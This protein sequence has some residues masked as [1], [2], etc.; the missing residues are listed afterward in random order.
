MR[1]VFLSSSDVTYVL[2]DSPL[3]VDDHL[4]EIVTFVDFSDTLN[5]EPVKQSLQNIDMQMDIGIEQATQVHCLLSTDG[6]NRIDLEGGGDLNMIY[7]TQ[8]GLRLFGRY[9]IVSGLMN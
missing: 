5:V 3:T 8:D 4:S 9:T 7:T 6:V 1:S 2:A